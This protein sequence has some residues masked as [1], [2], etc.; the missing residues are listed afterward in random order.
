[1]RTYM[2]SKS[3]VSQL[4]TDKGVSMKLEEYPWL[5]AAY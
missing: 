2:T 4:S 3:G 5:V 1:M